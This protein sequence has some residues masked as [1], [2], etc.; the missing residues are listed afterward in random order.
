M[1]KCNCFVVINSK[2]SPSFGCRFSNI[3]AVDKYYSQYQSY[4]GK[5]YCSLE[6]A[7][8]ESLK[9]NES[10]DPKNIEHF[11]TCGIFVDCKDGDYKENKIPFGGSDYSTIIVAGGSPS[12]IKT[13][14]I[15]FGEDGYYQAYLCDETCEIPE[16]Y[17]LAFK[18][19]DILKIYDDN[20]IVNTIRGNVIRVY[21]SGMRGC[22]IQTSD[23]EN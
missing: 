22:V 8:K 12:G 3:D 7:Y 17:E 6:K 18:C 4:N 15:W 13:G 5:I 10:L 2:E 19:E 20:G 1:E 11:V 23:D 21:R 14:T 9:L 16:N